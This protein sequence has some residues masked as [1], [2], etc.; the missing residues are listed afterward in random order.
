MKTWYAVMKDREDSDWGT[1]SHDLEEAK[2]MCRELG[3]DAYIAVIDGTIC[4][5]EITQDQF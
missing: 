3:S 2:R 5:E 1:G 4:I